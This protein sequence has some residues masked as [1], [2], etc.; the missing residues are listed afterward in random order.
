MK[1][2]GTRFY[3]SFD[4]QKRVP[5]LPKRLRRLLQARREDLAVEVGCLGDPW[6]TR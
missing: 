6:D 4:A 2:I 3:N 5:V 1:T